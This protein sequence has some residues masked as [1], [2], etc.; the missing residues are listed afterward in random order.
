MQIVEKSGE[1]LSRVYGV[2]VP[3]KDLAERL[4]T[5]IAEIT[6][7][8]NI[9][10]FRPGKVPPAHVRRL[11]GK[12]L[13]SEVVQQA[14]TETTQKVLDDNNLRPASD[15]DLKPEGDIEAVMDGK[16]DL[17]YELA[18][19]IMPDFQPV[20]AA[21]LSL[22]KP[23]YT[24]TDAEVDEAIADLAKQNRTYE[25][26]TGKS[27]KA[28]EGDQV[29]IDFIGRIDGEAFEGGTAEDVPLVLGS[30]QF[31]PGFEDQLIGAKPDSE[32]TVK[33][34]FP[35][36]YQ[37]ANLA[38][39]DAEF[40]TK[41][42]EV[43]APVD[44]AAD[45]ALAE[46]LGVE[47]LE[48]LKEL[49]KG[50]LEQQ[51]AGASRFK[52]KRA[53]LDQLDEKHDFPLP[54]KMVEAEFAAIWQQVQQDKEA[55]ELPEDDAKKTEEQLEK[56]YRRIAERRV[57]LG[58]VLA[59]IGRANNVTVTEQ[60]LAEA[61]RREAMKYGAQAQQ[62]FNLLRE[63]QNAQAQLRAPIFED[64]VVDLIVSKAKVDDKA[65]SK[66]ELLKEDDLPEGYEG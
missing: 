34:T 8:L 5:R 58:L 62:V 30:G 23:V 40:E 50:N 22:S 17:A 38:G 12:A 6:P 39:K 10:G 61:I 56:E 54:P 31:I 36:E 2:T 26:R 13:M 29:V 33:V 44:S 7:T 42:K 65:V 49:V 1:G 47:N 18:I 35:A 60:E 15:P 52:L 57:R 14:L 11:Y 25:P 19:D 3:Q 41:V 9:K 21:T 43:R 45:D 53:L 63:N 55:G 46:R 51:Y 28:K 4:E 16:A 37:A 32:L 20:D 48:K 66:D 27:V 64:K 24:P 59:E